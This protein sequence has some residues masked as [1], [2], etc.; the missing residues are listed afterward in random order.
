MGYSEAEVLTSSRIINEHTKLMCSVARL[1]RTVLH[2][3]LLRTSHLCALISS[4][5]R[6]SRWSQLVSRDF[7]DG[8]TGRSAMDSVGYGM[9]R[10][11][12]DNAFASAGA[13]RVN[14]E[15]NELH[16]CAAVNEVQRMCRAA[17]TRN[18]MSTSFSDSEHI[19]HLG[20]EPSKTR[21]VLSSVG[22][23][24]TCLNS[25]ALSSIGG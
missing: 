8:F 5:T 19:Q 24:R 4:R 11:L 3:A 23:T 7:P 22:S 15:V 2:A 6:R 10:R 9:T 16:D 17:L 21:M 12:A 25:R 14:V 13:N 18:G 1:Y 20:C